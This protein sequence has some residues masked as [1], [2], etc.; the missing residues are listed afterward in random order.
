M[1]L[2]LNLKPWKHVH[3]ALRFGLASGRMES[4]RGAI[5]PY[6]V[7]MFGENGKPVMDENDEPV[8]I[9]K[10]RRKAIYDENNRTPWAIPFDVK[11]SFYFF[12]RKGKG[13]G[14]FYV[15]IENLASLF[16]K[17]LRGTTFN[18][19]TGEE[20]SGSS[21]ATYDMPFPMPSVGFTWRY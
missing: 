11:F 2:V 10:Y 1:N 13:Q 14:E 17:P 16:Y 5:E 4:V 6:Q 19:Y 18:S 8:I 9:R 20:N 7:A 21:N 12:N 3:I 15:A